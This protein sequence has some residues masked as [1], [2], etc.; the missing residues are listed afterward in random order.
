MQNLTQNN[1]GFTCQ[2][3]W[4]NKTFTRK[5]G[6]NFKVWGLGEE[7]LDMTWKAQSTKERDRL[8]FIKIKNVCFEKDSIKRI[9]RQ[10]TDWEK[11][12]NHKFDG[13]VPRIY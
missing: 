4:I 3:I 9:K 6:E 11:F 12:A 10:T 1:Y 5:I 13:L 7:F 8:D 2:N